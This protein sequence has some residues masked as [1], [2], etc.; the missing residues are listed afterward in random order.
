MND[1]FI[2]TSARKAIMARLASLGRHFCQD[3]I[4]EMVSMT[5]ERF[6]TR[7]AFDP[8]RA[9]LQTY[10][11]R[12]ASRVVYDFVKGVDK[13]RARFCDIDATGVSDL[14]EDDWRAD[15]PLLEEEKDALL[16]KAVN[17][18]KPRHQLI[19]G[20]LHD[21]LTY[22]EIA[23]RLD[24]SVD[25]VTLEVHRMKKKLQEFVRAAA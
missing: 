13:A 25:N 17:R 3:D 10:V 20:Y 15:S 9:S 6:Y 4:D 7:G 22:P 11:S 21:E 2:I 8:A 5:I 24:I 23:S 1:T 12:I 18:L 14:L 16:E 19:F